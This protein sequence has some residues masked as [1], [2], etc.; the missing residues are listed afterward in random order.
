MTFLVIKKKMLVFPRPHTLSFFPSEDY[1][2]SAH[3]DIVVSQ[4]ED[5][6][7]LSVR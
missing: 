2:S 7:C 4:S 6:P 3:K 1:V 5:S